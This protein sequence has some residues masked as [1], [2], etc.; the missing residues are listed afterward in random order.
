M[1]TRQ[2][3]VT[4][5][6]FATLYV[7]SREWRVMPVPGAGRQWTTKNGVVKHHGDWCE[8]CAKTTGSIRTQCWRG[9]TK[10]WRCDAQ[11]PPGGLSNESHASTRVMIAC[12]IHC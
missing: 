8:H 11:L 12:Q 3:L 5:Q 6:R 1:S 9:N 2:T 7:D 10:R 4:L